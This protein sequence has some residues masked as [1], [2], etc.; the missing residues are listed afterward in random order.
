[1]RLVLEVSEITR[2]LW[3]QDKP[4]F[5]RI[6]ATDWDE[7]GEKGGDG[8]WRSWGLEQSTIL[9]KELQKLDIDLLDVSTGGNFA[10]QKIPVVPG[11]QV[12]HAEHIRKNVPGLIV[13]S[14]GLITDGKQG[15]S[16]CRLGSVRS[17]LRPRRN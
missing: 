10:K 4:V 17:P 7:E 6:S 3:P 12:P 14:V 11:Y 1:M 5:V 15:E 13:S 16:V 2:K 9:A 8:S